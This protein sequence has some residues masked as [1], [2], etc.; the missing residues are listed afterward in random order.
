[1]NKT[2]YEFVIA[3]KSEDEVKALS[4]SD[5]VSPPS[6]KTILPNGLPNFKI[7]FTFATSEDEAFRKVDDYVQR[8]PY[9]DIEDRKT[10]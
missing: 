8:T 1:M 10:I 9:K 2:A 4:E 5:E 7:L 3:Y 6:V